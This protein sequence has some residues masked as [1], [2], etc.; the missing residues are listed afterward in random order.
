MQ[1]QKHAPLTL[2]LLDWS[3]SGRFSHRYAT[4]SSHCVT[5]TNQR[6]TSQ[7]GYSRNNDDD[8]KPSDHFPRKTGFR[9]SKNER[10][11]SW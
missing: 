7:G 6:Q 4:R 2:L 3:Q 10:I 1:T 5:A 8:T 9:F 11:P